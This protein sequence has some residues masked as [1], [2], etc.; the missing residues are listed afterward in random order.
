MKKGEKSG[1]S[2]GSD[3]GKSIAEEKGKRTSRRTRIGMNFDPKAFKLSDQ[4]AVGKYLVSYGFHWIPRI[5]I[6]FF[7]MLL[8]FPRPRLIRR[9]CICIP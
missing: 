2:D 9:V 7:P 5:K 4:E 3:K 8:M 6:E 1:P